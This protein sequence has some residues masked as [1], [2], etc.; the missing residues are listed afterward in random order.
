MFI[1]I[2]L[3]NIRDIN[4]FWGIVNFVV[5]RLVLFFLFI[6][7]KMKVRFEVLF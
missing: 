7:G 1:I 3:I 6:D 4:S 5:G 2:Y